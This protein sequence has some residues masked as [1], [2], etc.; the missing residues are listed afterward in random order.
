M[1]DILLIP[2]PPYFNHL[3]VDIFDF[4]H[5]QDADPRKRMTITVDYGK[6]DVDQLTARGMDFDAIMAYYKDW[7]YDQV[8]YRLLEDWNAVSGLD[9]TLKIV[10]DHVRPLVL[11]D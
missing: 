9:E 4:P 3:E 11:T 6:Y 5:G 8:R 7:I 10:E 1:K 2:Q